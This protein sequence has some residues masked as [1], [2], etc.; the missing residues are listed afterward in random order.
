MSA[1]SIL[2]HD[3]ANKNSNS[4]GKTWPRWPCDTRARCPCYRS[5]IHFSLGVAQHNAAIANAFERGGHGHAVVRRH[6]RRL[7]GPHGLDEVLLRALDGQIDLAHRGG[8]VGA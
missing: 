5:A 4:N 1:S 8:R 2:W 6:Q 3:K 7:A